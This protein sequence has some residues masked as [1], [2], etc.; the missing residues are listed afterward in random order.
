MGLHEVTARERE[1]VG[2]KGKGVRRQ[3][4]PR[5]PPSAPQLGAALRMQQDLLS[6]LRAHGAG[7]AALLC[8]SFPT[9]PPSQCGSR[10]PT[11]VSALCRATTSRAVR[12]PAA[13]QEAP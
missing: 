1:T 8:L 12:R 4:S 11:P 3:G 9:A 13:P 10:I 5:A 7:Q 2:E 6:P